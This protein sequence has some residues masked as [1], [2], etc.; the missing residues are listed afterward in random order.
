[1]EARALSGSP[2][3]HAAPAA[4]DCC[5]CVEVAKGPSSKHRLTSNKAPIIAVTFAAIVSTNTIV[6]TTASGL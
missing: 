1:M 4:R 3:S 2:C 6:S 5:Q